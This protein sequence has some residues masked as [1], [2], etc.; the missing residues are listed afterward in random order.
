MGIGFVMFGKAVVL[1][2]WAVLVSLWKHWKARRNERGI[3]LRYDKRRSS[4]VADDWPERV[5]IV[6][7]RAKVVLLWFGAINAAVW[8]GLLAYVRMFT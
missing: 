2:L 4:Y 6:L 7:Y 8:L 5:E 3:P 1:G